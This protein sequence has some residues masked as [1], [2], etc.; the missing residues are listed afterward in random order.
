MQPQGWLAPP[1][2]AVVCAPE[3]RSREDIVF[4]LSSFPLASSG[5]HLPSPERPPP[6]KNSCPPKSLSLAL[7]L[8]NPAQG[9]QCPA[10]TYLYATPGIVINLGD[11]VSK[12]L[13]GHVR[14]PGWVGFAGDPMG[15]MRQG[16]C[17]ISPSP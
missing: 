5:P 8:G 12:G 11:P 16:F 14:G 10:V 7:L 1:P 9:H 6:L 15:N 13:N 17:Q 3:H 2:G 4:S